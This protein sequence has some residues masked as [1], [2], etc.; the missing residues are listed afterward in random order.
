MH[1]VQTERQWLSQPVSDTG[2][3]WIDYTK[4]KLT[5]AK[6]HL[7]QSMLRSVKDHGCP[8]SSKEEQMRAVQGN[9]QE[10]MPP[11]RPHTF[12]A[13]KVS[14]LLTQ[15][16]VAATVSAGKVWSMC[17]AH[18]LH[19]QENHVQAPCTVHHAWCLEVIPW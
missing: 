19:Q 1:N 18:K 15:P 16:Q 13:G 5:A 6:L 12:P 9:L 17:S 7:Q 11:Y 4:A 14:L 3:T 2:G 10:L 8:A